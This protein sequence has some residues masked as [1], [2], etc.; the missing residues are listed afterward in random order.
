MGAHW[1]ATVVSLVA[2]CQ[3]HGTEPEAYLVRTESPG[4]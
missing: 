2:S 1:N 4:P 3:L